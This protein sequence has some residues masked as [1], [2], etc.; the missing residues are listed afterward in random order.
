MREITKQ[1]KGRDGFFK[2][3]PI[4]LEYKSKRHAYYF[5]RDTFSG[6]V[7]GWN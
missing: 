1:T 3:L 7:V 4:S 6:V 5:T 2:Q